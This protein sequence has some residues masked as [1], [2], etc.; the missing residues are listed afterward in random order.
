ML[1]ADTEILGQ[2]DNLHLFRNLMFAQ[3]CL[4]LAVPEAE[5]YH[6]HLVKWHFRS[7]RQPGLAYES[8]VHFIHFIPGITLAVGKDYLCLRMVQQEADQFTSCIASGSQD[9]NTYGSTTSFHRDGLGNMH[10][11]RLR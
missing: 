9:A 8:L 7:K 2:V 11:V 3:E 6:I 5:E 1:A 10:G 4:A